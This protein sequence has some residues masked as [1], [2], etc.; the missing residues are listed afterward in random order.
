[1]VKPKNANSQKGAVLDSLGI[2]RVVEL[3]SV[4]KCR[5]KLLS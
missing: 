3:F 1:L 2:K 5:E 4:R